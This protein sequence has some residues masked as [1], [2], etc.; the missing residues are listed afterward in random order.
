MTLGAGLEGTLAATCHKYTTL[1]WAPVWCLVLNFACTMRP[2]LLT[3]TE[4]EEMRSS[5]T[6]TK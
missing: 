4:N 3:P 6:I 2:A 5:S 1:S